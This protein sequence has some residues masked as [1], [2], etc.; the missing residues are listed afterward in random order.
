MNEW[1]D[2]EVNFG[3]YHGDFECGA[4]GKP[5]RKEIYVCSS[6]PKYYRVNGRYELNLYDRFNRPFYKFAGETMQQ[7]EIYRP[8]MYLSCFEGE[9]PRCKWRIFKGGV[10]DAF[11]TEDEEL[12]GS[13]WQVLNHADQWEDSDLMVKDKPCMKTG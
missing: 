3:V 1:K 10:T 12:F 2:A 11:K 5:L 7:D 6:N 13:N 4:L 9:Q 8:E